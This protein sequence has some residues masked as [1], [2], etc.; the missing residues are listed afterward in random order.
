MN[1]VERVMPAKK[2][3]VVTDAATLAVMQL[4]ADLSGKKIVIENAHDQALGKQLSRATPD[5][6]RG[7]CIDENDDARGILGDNLQENIAQNIGAGEIIARAQQDNPVFLQELLAKAE[8]APNFQ[9]ERAEV[10][11]FI[12]DNTF[13]DQTPNKDRSGS[14]NRQ[15]VGLVWHATVSSSWRTNVTSV[16]EFLLRKSSK[17]SYNQV[18]PSHKVR[19]EN[20]IYNIVSK[21]FVAWHAGKSFFINPRNGQRLENFAVNE[22]TFGVAIDFS[23]KST[24]Q[25]TQHQFNGM[26][27]SALWAKRTLNVP[28]DIAYHKL[29]LEVAPKRKF[30]IVRN[31]ITLQ[32]VIDEAIRIEREQQ[33]S[34]EIDPRTGA[35]E[36]SVLVGN[37]RKEATTKSPIVQT[38]KLGTPI[39]VKKIKEGE[40]VNKKGN[41]IWGGLSNGDDNITSWAHTSIYKPRLKNTIV[42]MQAALKVA[43]DN[44][45]VMAAETRQ[46]AE[47]KL[48]RVTPSISR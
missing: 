21:A 32:R 23:N 16:I 41:K 8:A 24:D 38:V 44:L 1:L 28:L 37:L 29:H 40:D 9:A 5:S 3:V 48:R 31:A 12:F 11:R 17:V 19:G 33:G 35:Q 26:V 15:Y 36:I 34:P 46:K 27:A 47:N 42:R 39:F 18:I 10:E 4:N 14:P 6:V 43:P 30:D 13:L 25:I 20:R 7:C 2:F 22:N 45:R